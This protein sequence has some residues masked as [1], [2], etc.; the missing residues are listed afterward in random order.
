MGLNI[1]T[2]YD[3]RV[4]IWE[5]LKNTNGA[6]SVR[7]KFTTSGKNRDGEWETD[8]S[9]FI[10]FKGDAA[11]QMR[12]KYDDKEGIAFNRTPLRIQINNGSVYQTKTVRKDANGNQITNRDGKP[13][14]TYYT[15]V[16]VFGFTFVD[17]NNTTAS[18]GTATSTRQDSSFVNLP[19]NAI[20]EELPFA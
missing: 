6:K 7:A 9:G 1:G 4:T 8:F 12:E 19:D 16:D 17:N 5:I 18:N 11:R 15:N 20:D 3:A 2:K 14:Y 13:Y 10:N